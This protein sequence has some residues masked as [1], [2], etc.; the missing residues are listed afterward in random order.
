MLLLLPKRG[1]FLDFSNIVD[2]IKE[3]S[4]SVLNALDRV[5]N[6]TF[7]VYLTNTKDNETF[8]FPVNPLSLTINRE[9]KYNTADIID[10]GEIDISDKGT[11]IKEISMETLIPDVYE[12]YCR[13]T[14]IA[15]SK[16]TVEKLE[17]WKDQEEPLRLIITVIGFNSL[18][19]LSVMNEEI[20]PEGLNNN[21]YFTFTFRT[22]RDL[23]ISQV[24]S[25]LQD[26]R[27]TTAESSGAKYSHRE[28]EWIVVTADVLNVR[29][30]PGES[31][32]I[33]GTVKKDECY[34]IGSIQGNWADI[35]WSNHGG[36]I[37][38]DYVR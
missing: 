19:N 22:H 16:E 23:K 5:A 20:R 13:Y 28:G 34:K 36:W 32:G 3:A 29:D 27:Q 15:D 7:D 37:N 12:P 18:V 38:T 2:V 14:D 33:R 30:G 9:K 17:K 26:N 11:K 25:T 31:Y 35:Y 6:S 1:D 24:D 21:R 4:E 10:I 8:H